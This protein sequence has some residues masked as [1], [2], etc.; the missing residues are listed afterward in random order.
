MMA[1][2]RRKVNERKSGDINK[3]AWTFM[4]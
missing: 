2:L 1:R 4:D 3:D